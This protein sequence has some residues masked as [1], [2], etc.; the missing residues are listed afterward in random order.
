M[1]YAG[2][3]GTRNVPMQTRLEGMQSVTQEKSVESTSDAGAYQGNNKCSQE[4]SHVI[5]GN[6]QNLVKA[7]TVSNVQEVMN[8][9]QEKKL[10][11]TNSDMSETKKQ[12][13]LQQLH[14]IHERCNLKIQKLRFEVSLEKKIA[15]VEKEGN[16][17]QAEEIR[18]D[19]LREKNIRKSDEYAEL[20]RFIMQN[21]SYS[22]TRSPFIYNI[23]QMGDDLLKKEIQSGSYIDFRSMDL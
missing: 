13:S 2:M 17:E 6:M 9:L 3:A 11:I 19:Y 5:I 12:I 1:F 21:N 8:T 23:E 15:K 20:Q 10:E 7:E 16:R 22:S 14:N 18:Q 4:M